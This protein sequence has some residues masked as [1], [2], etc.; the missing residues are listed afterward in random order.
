MKNYFLFELQQLIKSKKTIG[1][2]CLLVIVA[3]VYSFRDRTYRPIERI[4]KN[5]I[6]QRYLT[7]Q[8]FL[9]EQAENP[10]DHW[11]AAMAVAMFEPWNQADS[12]RLTSLAA[13]DWQKYAKATS[14]WYQLSL[15][16][17]DD[18]TIFFTPDYY[19]YQNYYAAYDGKYGY[20]STAKW[21]ESA[22]QLPNKKLSKYVLEQKTGIQSVQR[23]FTKYLPFLFLG[24]TIFLAIDS[25]TKDRRHKSLFLSLPVTVDEILWA[26]TAALFIVSTLMMI[27]TL[28]LIWIGVGC[29][30]GFGSLD[31]PVSILSSSFDARYPISSADVF[32]TRPVGVFLLQCMGVG[33]VLQLIYIRG[34]LLL[35]TLWRS[36][37]ANLFLAGFGLISPLIFQRRWFSAFLDKSN[38]AYLYQN[39]GQILSGFSRF[40]FGSS[41]F[42]LAKGLLLFGVV[43]LLIE[44]GLFVR[45]QQKQFKLV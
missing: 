40:Y 35:S 15:Q 31:L 42:V 20:A 30:F 5:E 3:G 29:Q 28:V 26:K 33:I 27:S 45:V 1:L 4:D 9:D 34:I 38:D 18:E 8:S 22:S 41:E 19:T 13:N 11:S 10:S 12:L 43:W 2:W 32:Y 16:Y 7:R 44:I 25:L 23:A 24:V 39:Y 17:T 37:L 36:E 21:M 14:Q 6:E